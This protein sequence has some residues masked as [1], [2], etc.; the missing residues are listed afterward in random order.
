[1]VAKRGLAAICAIVLIRDS[2]SA[3]SDRLLRRILILGSGGEIS[4]IFILGG[5]LSSPRRRGANTAAAL[6]TGFDPEDVGH[7]DSALGA[8]FHD[9]DVQERVQ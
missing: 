5:E 9:A 3:S 8:E 6:D 2:R 4:Q 7:I 1:M